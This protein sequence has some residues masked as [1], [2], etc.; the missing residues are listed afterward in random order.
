LLEGI[1]GLSDMA[2]Q[3]ADI[4]AAINY[5]RYLEA[6]DKQIAQRHRELYEDMIK[7]T[8]ADDDLD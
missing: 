7:E 8:I 2:T 3:Q 4:A 6:H 1:K 5:L